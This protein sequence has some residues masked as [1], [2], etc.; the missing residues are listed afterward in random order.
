MMTV[1]NKGLQPLVYYLYSTSIA[2]QLTE[3]GINH[4]LVFTALN[5]V[6]TITLTPPQHIR[7]A[8]EHGFIR[9]TRKTHHQQPQSTNDYDVCFLVSPRLAL[10][11]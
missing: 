2:Q 3:F 9:P 6:H 8:R 10:A 7:E 4:T 5:D 1:H 11:G